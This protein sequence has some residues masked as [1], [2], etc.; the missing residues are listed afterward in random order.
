[1]ISVTYSFELSIP[2]TQQGLKHP[3]KNI[4]RIL[5]GKENFLKKHYMQ[6]KRE[7]SSKKCIPRDLVFYVSNLDQKEL[8]SKQ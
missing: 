5:K 2:T 4:A 6:E 1:M 7:K 8:R 3:V